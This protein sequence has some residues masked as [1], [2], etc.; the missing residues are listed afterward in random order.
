MMAARNGSRRISR[1]NS[2]ERW[3]SSPALL[4]RGCQTSSWCQSITPELTLA[5]ESR[6]LKGRILPLDSLRPLTFDT[7]MA[8]GQA[9]NR[10]DSL[11]AAVVGLKTSCGR[12]ARLTCRFCPGEPERRYLADQLFP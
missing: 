3:F 10:F 7:E 6:D 1:R 4:S 2:P 9:S 11:G 5:H 12:N 8:W